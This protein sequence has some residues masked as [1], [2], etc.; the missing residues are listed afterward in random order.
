MGHVQTLVTAIQARS[1]VTRRWLLQGA[2]GLVA[3]RVCASILTNGDSPVA[4]N[5]S[6][7]YGQRTLPVGVRSRQIDNTNGATLHILEAGFESPKRRCVVLL[8]GFPELTYSWRK[9]LQPLARAGFHVIAPDLR[10][11]GRSAPVPVA[12]HDDL[13][14]YSMLNRVGD[15]L[16]IVHAKRRMRIRGTHR[17]ASLICSGRCITSRAPTGRAT[18]RIHSSLGV[19]P[20]LPR[21]QLLSCGIRRGPHRICWSND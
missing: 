9:Q 21:F 18:S 10:G 14:P 8:H 20:S 15:V 5:T 17:R 12:F 3:G 19:R 7:L 4:T 13:A 1:G 16:G 11:Y 6:V 2:A